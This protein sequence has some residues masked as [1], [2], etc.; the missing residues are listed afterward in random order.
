MPATAGTG[1]KPL[2]V[3]DRPLLAEDTIK[4]EQAL[5]HADSLALLTLSDT[6]KLKKKRD[7]ATWRPNPKRATCP[8]GS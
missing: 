1:T 7:W 6:L 5:T 2:F 4:A 8:C 3:N